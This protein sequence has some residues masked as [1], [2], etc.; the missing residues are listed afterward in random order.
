MI[1]L[2]T[3]NS[4]LKQVDCI[5]TDSI[6]PKETLKAA[7]QIVASKSDFQIFGVCA[8]SLSEGITALA[9]YAQA[10][11][12]A[13][14]DDYQLDAIDGSIYIKFNPKAGLIYADS[15]QGD[16]RGVLVSCQSAYA[17]GLNEMYGHLPLDLFATT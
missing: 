15:Y 6:P 8:N 4:I 14:P 5:R 12:Y 2:T 13:L 10:L 11:G 7:L 9:Q 16:H 3:A 17:D 1:N